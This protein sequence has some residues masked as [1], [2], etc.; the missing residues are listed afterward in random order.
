M[1]QLLLE[2]AVGPFWAFIRLRMNTLLRLFLCSVQTELQLLLCV[3]LGKFY[4]SVHVSDSVLSKAWCML[5]LIMIGLTD[6][7][8]I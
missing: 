2:P 5:T 7:V 6:F 3:F 8:P 1:S 4:N